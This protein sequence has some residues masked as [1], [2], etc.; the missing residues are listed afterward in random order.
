MNSRLCCQGWWPRA[1]PCSVAQYAMRGA[2]SGGFRCPHRTGP[3]SV[4]RP[5]C[6]DRR[7]G[8]L[9]LP[10]TLGLLRLPG[11]PGPFGLLRLS[12]LSELLR[13]A[14]LLGLLRT[15]ALSG[16]FRRPGPSELVR[17]LR[18]PGMS[19]LVELVRLPGLLGLFRRFAAVVRR[20]GVWWRRLVTRAGPP[21]AVGDRGSGTVWMV[22]LIGL[23]WSVAVMAMTVGGVRAARHRAYAA[24]DLAA[25]AAASHATDGAR[26]ACRFAARIAQ[27]SGGQLRRCVVH[28]RVSEVMVVSGLRD[29]P[30]LGRLNA[31]A[32]AR[33]GPVSAPGACEPPLPCDGSRPSYGRV[34]PPLPCEPPLPCDGS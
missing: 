17:M 26:S 11:L 28:G 33:A 10:G 15:P 27:G 16:L 30:G 20:A 4:R 2:A 22:G 29:V 5:A 14:G 1:R 25:L 23:I 31:S 3:R 19:G 21:R 13:P 6:R 18:R 8:H 32:R 9:R 34:K 7:V 12:G 24:A